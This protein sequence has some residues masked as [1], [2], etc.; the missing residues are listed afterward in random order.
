MRRS[1]TPGNDELKRSTGYV[2]TS[3]GC[4]AR[5]CRIANLLV[6]SH[7]S[8][9]FSLAAGDFLPVNHWSAFLFLPLLPANSRHHV[10]LSVRWTRL[11][12]RSPLSRQ[13]HSDV[14][15]PRPMVIFFLIRHDRLTHHAVRH[16]PSFGKK[17]CLRGRHTVCSLSPVSVTVSV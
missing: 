2:I 15:E 14:L 11:T 3:A 9:T 6:V 10:A 8:S 7:S 5:S 1:S 4:A 12:V 16:T 17:D 13:V